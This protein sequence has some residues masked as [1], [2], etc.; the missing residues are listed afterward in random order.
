[1]IIALQILGGFVCLIFGAEW[2][3]RGSVRLAA[4]FGMVGGPL[5]FF[6]GARL[7]AADL[8]PDLWISLGALALEWALAMPLLLWLAGRFPVP[9]GYRRL[10]PD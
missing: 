10:D 1:M 5:A 2:L 9:P 7:G 3:V 6:G 8:H 4:L